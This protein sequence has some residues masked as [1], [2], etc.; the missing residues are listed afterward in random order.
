MN[1]PERWVKNVIKINVIK[2][3]QQ[4]GLSTFDK[5]LKQL[6]IFLE[7]FKMYKLFKIVILFSQIYSSFHS[8]FFFEQ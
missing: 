1:K 8:K 3:I 5:W 6:N 2:I 4:L 7:Y